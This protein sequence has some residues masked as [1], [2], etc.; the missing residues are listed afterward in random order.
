MPKQRVT[1]K[2]LW[3]AVRKQCVECVGG[4]TGL[5]STC[6][7][8]NC[9]LFLYRFGYRSRTVENP[10]KLVSLGISGNTQRPQKRVENEKFDI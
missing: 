6:P 1:L 4:Q 8:K 2:K 7:T 3:D 9:S 10:L 5:I